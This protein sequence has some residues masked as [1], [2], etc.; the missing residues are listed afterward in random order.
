MFKD[1][2]LRNNVLEN[3]E[4]GS[5]ATLKV[6]IAKKQAFFEC[7]DD[8]KKDLDQLVQK[9]LCITCVS[10]YACCCLGQ[11]KAMWAR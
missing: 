1:I 5:Y 10:A 7:M 3:E 11:M 4:T 8:T 6:L 9:S 2:F